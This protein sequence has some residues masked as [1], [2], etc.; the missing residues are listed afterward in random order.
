MLKENTVQQILAHCASNNS[1]PIA[2]QAGEYSWAPSNLA[3]C[4][5]WGKRDEELNLPVT[6]SLSIALGNKGTLTRISYVQNGAGDVYVVNGEELSAKTDFAKRLHQYLNLFRPRAHSH[7]QAN[8]QESYLVET[9]STVPIAAG[10]ASSASGYA[11]LILALNKFYN[12][13]LAKKEL[14]IL[15]RLGSGSACRSLWG[16]F[17]EWQKGEDQDGMDSYA[18]PLSFIWPELRIGAL[19]I[20]TQAKEI[21]SRKA[22]QHTVLTSKFY[23]MWPAQVEL[24]MHTLHKALAAKDF[25]LFGSTSEHNSMMMHALMQSA[26]PPIVYTREFTLAA[27]QRVWELRRAGI[28]VFFTQD[29]GANLQLLFLAEN[30]NVVVSAFTDLE[31]IQPFVDFNAEKLILVDENDKEIGNGEKTAIHIKGQLHRAFS[32]VITRQRSDGAV[33]LLLQQRSHQKYH[34]ADLWTNTCCGHPRPGENI[35]VAARQRL[36]EEMGIK[37]SL[38]LKE[39]G[40][41][42]YH[43]NLPSSNLIEHEID[44]VFVG[45]LRCDE[46]LIIKPNASEVQDY[47]WVNISDLLEDLKT[48]PQRYTAW[49]GDVINLFC[50][51]LAAK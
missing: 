37:N 43:A 12:W 29:A 19:I 39:I 18:K 42:H 21:S 45:E 31:I 47:R 20:S 32:V 1:S 23:P 51:Y 10:F 40:T 3:L 28:N 24:D 13:N 16:G 41:F 15:A 34:S 4:K 14:S 36:Y 2:N 46:E 49:L 22:M 38:P 27:M 8:T 6:S 50:D 26:Q 9:E 44:H 7:L 35:L 30:E 48:N 5:Y 17:V 33:E 25:V 11:A